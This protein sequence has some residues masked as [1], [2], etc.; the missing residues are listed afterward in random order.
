MSNRPY[1]YLKYWTDDEFR[2]YLYE[3]MPTEQLAFAYTHSICNKDRPIR[4]THA[5]SDLNF[6][7]EE[8]IPYLLSHLKGRGVTPEANPE[9]FV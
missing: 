6:T 2:C 3:D 7:A 4:V 9:L 5:D 8:F 1:I